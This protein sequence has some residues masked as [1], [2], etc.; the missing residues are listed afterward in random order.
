MLAIFERHLYLTT[1]LL[2]MGVPVILA[3]K[4]DGR[5]ASL[6]QQSY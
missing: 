3:S 5:S 6:T 2:E 1:H 4:Y